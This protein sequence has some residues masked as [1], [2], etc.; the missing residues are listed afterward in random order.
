MLPTDILTILA[1]LGFCVSWFC[2]GAGRRDLLLWLTACA[3]LLFAVLGYSNHRG[4]AIISIAVSVLFVIA[5]IIRRLRGSRTP[6]TPPW[7]TGALFSLLTALAVFGYWSFPIF[8]LPEPSGDYAV[9]VRDFD[10]TDTSRNGV[11]A[12][13]PDEPRRLRVRVWYP[14]G[15]VE[16]LQPRAYFNDAEAATSGR[17]MGAD[18]F[19]LPW[20]YSHLR[21]VS[22]HSFENAPLL[23]DADQQPV[24]FFSHGYGSIAGQNTSVMEELAS[25]G[26]VV[27]SVSH[28]YD[29]SD[30]FFA[31]G[32]PIPRDHNRWQEI[33]D[34]A[35]PEDG[36]D[37]VGHFFPPSLTE[38][39]AAE[40]RHLE[41]YVKRNKR[42]YRSVAIW[43]D[44]RL[45]VKDEL[46]AGRV[47]PAIA[48][49]AAASDFSQVGHT[50]M[51]FG[52]S[53]GP[54]V[55][56]RDADCAAALNLD[57]GNFDPQMFNRNHE[58]PLLVFMHDWPL[59]FTQMGGDHG[60]D[61][62]E[63]SF[64]DFSYE[65]H[66]AA[67]TRDDI[68][69]LRVKNVVHSGVTD[70]IMLARGPV[71]SALFGSIDGPT[72]L[73]IMNDFARG[74]FDKHLRGLDNDFPEAQFAQYSDDVVPHD[75]GKVAQWWNSLSDSERAGLPSGPD[76]A[77][78]LIAA[79]KAGKGAMNPI[80]TIS[81]E[82]GRQI[83]LE[84]YPEQAPQSV[85]SFI[86]LAETGY[87][88][89]QPLGRVE[90]D[91]LIQGGS[92]E[93]DWSATPGYA[94]RGEFVENGVDNRT[95]FSPGT[96]G[97]GRLTPDSGGSVWFITTGNSGSLDGKYAAFGHVIGGLDHVVELSRIPAKP[98]SEEVPFVH[99]PLQPPTVKSITVETFG[100]DYPPPEKLPEMTA[101]QAAAEMARAAT[102]SPEQAVQSNSEPGAKPLFMS[103]THV[104][105][106]NRRLAASEAVKAEAAKLD[107][108]YLMV[109]ELVQGDKTHWWQMSFDPE[110]GVAFSLAE[111][112]AKPDMLMKGDYVEF[113]RFM[114]QFAAGKAAAADQPVT[115]SGYESFM[116]KVGAAYAVAAKAAGVPVE[117]PQL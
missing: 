28:T 80:A 6:S 32:D 29:T 63:F 85:R 88:N 86:H 75:A 10:L 72:M 65:E 67:G 110:E 87:Y 34:D 50:G 112:T 26:Y 8:E 61:Y 83:S 70:F 73:A 79:G 36:E 95:H 47:P 13:A 93:L 4:V 49:I 11:L 89:G 64:T 44:D 53:T 43:I 117:F 66:S 102:K 1:L 84:L 109:H 42:F 107:R 116:E 3:A 33:V 59:M 91:R 98:F 38:R 60:W 20:L 55:C 14:A 97:F 54:S 99:T 51:S 48:E 94:I 76:I 114:Q 45:F 24:V 12:A 52:G 106:M 77:G 15:S 27:Y 71:K 113:I 101:E 81:M 46:K 9:G 31:N 82:D 56:Y 2:T 18:R 30:G 35:L 17:Y 40:I 105:I 7:F 41:K 111:P 21:H 39:R 25:H 16:N 19:K 22:T 74:F 37:S 108:R 90:K 96:I 62:S 23:P 115:I 78:S 57:G 58:K 103:A 68:Y 92:D 100:V 69:R 5:L 104:D